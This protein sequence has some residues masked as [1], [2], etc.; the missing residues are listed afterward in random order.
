[1]ADGQPE[2]SAAQKQRDDVYSQRSNPA[3]E[4]VLESR[5]AARDAAFFLPFLRP[6]MRVMDVGCGPGTITVGLAE[7][8]PPGRVDGFDLHPSMLHRARPIPSAQKVQ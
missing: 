5:T 2:E 7:V 6:G 1:M 8:V 4:G 3:F